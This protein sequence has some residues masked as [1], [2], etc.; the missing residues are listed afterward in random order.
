MAIGLASAVFLTALS[1]SAQTEVRPVALPLEAPIGGAAFNSVSALP[2]RA[3]I[4]ALT[5][6]A[7]NIAPV[8]SAAPGALP[9][10]AAAAPVPA[11]PASAA[12][13]PLSPATAIADV[14]P[15][16]D[17]VDGN[18]VPRALPAAWDNRPTRVPTFDQL[19]RAAERAQAY[20]ARTLSGETPEIV[21]AAPLEARVGGVLLDEKLQNVTVEARGQRHHVINQD[22]LY[23]V[24][25]NAGQA[26]KDGF[27]GQA[28]RVGARMKVVA[29][30]R[31]GRWEAPADARPWG[32]GDGRFIV[33][34][35]QAQIG[36][37]LPGVA[38][39]TAFLM[40]DP[41]SLVETPEETSFEI[42]FLNPWGAQ[43][44][45]PPYA[46]AVGRYGIRDHRDGTATVFAYWIGAAGSALL[47]PALRETRLG[48]ALKSG[49]DWASRAGLPLARDTESAVL[50]A[51]R[52]M[53]RIGDAALSATGAT[54]ALFPIAA[55]QH[56]RF[57]ERDWTSPERWGQVAAEKAGASSVRFAPMTGPLRFLP[58]ETDGAF[59]TRAWRALTS[60]RPR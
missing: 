22:L 47:E 5:T 26:F 40:M 20:A 59:W 32:T 3:S 46:D 11:A 31:D 36:T 23:R 39:A 49:W 55:L 28:A 7:P 50:A 45:F 12:P 13:S 10:A 53:T 27:F 44:L 4:S 48:K 16:R 9:A 58:T 37:D 42:Q 60:A 25:P 18:H 2:V 17:D 38:A 6:K 51:A 14:P 34:A 21:A 8:L 30:E 33:Q 24:P 15:R 57:Y 35:D 29:V 43:G 1:A 54:E 56:V 41:K 19:V 52:V